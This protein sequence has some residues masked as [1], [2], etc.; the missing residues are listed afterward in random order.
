MDD[1]IS[2][3]AIRYRKLWDYDETGTGIP[4]IAVSNDEIDAIP[5][6]DVRPVVRGRWE[7][8]AGKVFPY[9]RCT[10]CQEVHFLEPP[11]AKFCPGCGADMREEESR[12]GGE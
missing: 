1:Y 8:I 5:P 4:V 2:R 3:Q 10:A 9:W 6:A 11:N 12:D 7:K